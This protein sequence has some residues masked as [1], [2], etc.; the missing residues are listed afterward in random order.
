LLW[1][2]PVEYCIV[3]G[4]I[5]VVFLFFIPVSDTLYCPVC[6]I[7]NYPEAYRCAFCNALLL[8]GDDPL[9]CETEAGQI[10]EAFCA[11]RVTGVLPA[12]GCRRVLVFMPGRSSPLQIEGD[13]PVILGRNLENKCGPH[14]E[15]IVDLS[16]FNALDKG[17]SRRHVLLKPV[18]DGY[19]IYDMGSANGSWLNQTR[20]LPGR[21]Y[22]LDRDSE[23][24][25]GRMILRLAVRGLG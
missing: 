10:E 9:T 4:N 12:Q 16:P 18:A 14:G 17:V 21:V 13:R 11:V 25:L 8:P 19:E 22:H 6:K 15:A 24:C 1:N 3:S 2:F 23:I 7:E 5:T 20:M